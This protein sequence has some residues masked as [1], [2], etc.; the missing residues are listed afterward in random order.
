MPFKKG[1]V[2]TVRAFEAVATNS[3]ASDPDF[4]RLAV[5]AGTYEVV[6]VWSDGDVTLSCVPGL[7]GRYPIS[8]AALVEAALVKPQKFK[9]GDLVRVRPGAK[10][11]LGHPASEGVLTFKKY[12]I[13]HPGWVVTSQTAQL[14]DTWKEED[15]L[16][17][18]R[19]EDTHASL[20]RVFDLAVAQTQSGKG[21]DRHGNG[22]AFERQPIVT[23]NEVLGSN[24]GALFQVVKKANESA[25]LAATGRKD[26]AKNELLGAMVYLGA[27]YLLLGAE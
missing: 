24:H 26:M 27:A 11:F 16:F 13:E 20:R 7:D 8:K 18:S 6:N 17:V 9:K 2:I 5:P 14:A 12:L 15:V 21:A 19:E 4:L 22:E 3:D 23:I 25:R 1:D 10:S